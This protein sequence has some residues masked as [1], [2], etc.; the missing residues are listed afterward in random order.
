MMRRKMTI[1]CGETTRTR[2]SLDP[3]TMT[4]MKLPAKIGNNPRDTGMLPVWLFSTTG[5][6]KIANN[7]FLKEIF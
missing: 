2:F 4:S 1:F 7:C 6:P 3:K 5:L